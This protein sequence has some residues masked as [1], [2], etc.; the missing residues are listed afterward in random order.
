M[1]VQEI[2]NEM[3]DYAAILRVCEEHIIVGDPNEG[4]PE[5]TSMGL[6]TFSS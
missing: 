1:Y 2:A 5:D 3:P 4:P 6:I